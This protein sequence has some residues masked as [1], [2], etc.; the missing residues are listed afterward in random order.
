MHE[1]GFYKM[2][3]LLFQWSLF[4]SWEQKVAA[5]VS[6]LEEGTYSEKLYGFLYAHQFCIYSSLRHTPV[7]FSSTL[8]S[9]QEEG[10]P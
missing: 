2:D 9:T 5:G 8:I 6:L 7:P 4:C 3:N 10:T 1:N